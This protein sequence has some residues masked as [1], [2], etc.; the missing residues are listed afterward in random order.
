[1]EDIIHHP[2][3][4]LELRHDTWVLSPD[5]GL[6]SIKEPSDDN[7]QYQSDSGIWYSFNTCD[8]LNGLLLDFLQHTHQSSAGKNYDLDFDHWFIPTEK[9]DAKYSYKIER[10]HFPDIATIGP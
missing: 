2:G 4:H 5:T 6:G 3:P 7:V 9:Y 1:M 10:S 8:K